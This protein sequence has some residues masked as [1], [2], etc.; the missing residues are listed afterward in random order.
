[1]AMASTVLWASEIRKLVLR[2]IG[3]RKSRAPRARAGGADAGGRRPPN[4]PAPDSPIA[5]R[6]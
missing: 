3:G 6:S 5:H 2:L 1:V 4:P